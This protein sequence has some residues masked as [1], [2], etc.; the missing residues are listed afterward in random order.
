MISNERGKGHASK[1]FEEFFKMIDTNLYLSVRTPI[2]RLS[3]SIIRWECDK[4]E[5]PLG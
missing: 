3:V 1:V 4:L 5:K 2:I